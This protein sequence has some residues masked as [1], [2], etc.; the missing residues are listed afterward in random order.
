MDRRLY[1]ELWALRF[2]KML[3]LERG[4]AR[5][6]QAMLDE[7]KTKNKNHSI[8]PHLERLV[9]DEKKHAHLVEEL[10]EILNRQAV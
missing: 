6:Y 7:C 1:R 3:E 10:I 4:A 9:K 5:E 2:K 8:E